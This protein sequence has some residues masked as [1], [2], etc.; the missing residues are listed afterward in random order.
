M[1]SGT[2]LVIGLETRS[3]V[4]LAVIPIGEVRFVSTGSAETTLIKFSEKLL[5][6][7]HQLS[8]NRKFATL[9]SVL[10]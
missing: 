8:A 1:D 2:K 9:L 7:C 5:R 6:A 4:C 10:W 3:L